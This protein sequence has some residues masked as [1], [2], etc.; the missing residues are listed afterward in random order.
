MSQGLYEPESEAQ[1]QSA[2]QSQSQSTAPRANCTWFRPHHG[3]GANPKWL[4]IAGSSPAFVRATWSMAL[5]HASQR[6]DRGSVANF[7]LLDVASFLRVTLDE[8]QRI[9][10]CRK[11][12]WIA[13]MPPNI[14]VEAPRRCASCRCTAKD[15]RR[16]SL[17]LAPITAPRMSRP[18]SRQPGPPTPAPTEKGPAGA[19]RRRP[20]AGAAGVRF[21]GAASGR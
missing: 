2:G 1:Q 13:P 8:V 3:A 21:A 20:Y 17:V 18:S 16:T 15:H 10:R 5:E 11:A 14:S 9:D 6:E 12:G 19:R 4:A 7:V